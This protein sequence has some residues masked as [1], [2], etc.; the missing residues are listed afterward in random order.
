MD[1]QRNADLKTGGGEGK[2]LA[3]R[4]VQSEIGYPEHGDI[5]FIVCLQ[6]ETGQLSSKQRTAG[7]T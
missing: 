7:L 3:M 5:S 6:A 4:A 1:L 2:I